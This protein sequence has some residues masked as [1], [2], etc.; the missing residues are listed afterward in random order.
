M[1][2]KKVPWTSNG[3]NPSDRGRQADWSSHGNTVHG[4][5]DP[6]KHH[7]S[8]RQLSKTGRL[9]FG[10]ELDPSS[11]QLFS[12]LLVMPS[13][14]D[15]CQTPVHPPTAC[16]IESTYTN[17]NATQKEDGFKWKP[18]PDNTRQEA[19]KHTEQWPQERANRSPI[20]GFSFPASHSTADELAEAQQVLVHCSNVATGRRRGLSLG[21]PVPVL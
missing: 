15:I 18:F 8:A 14:D 12:Q 10:A 4:Q 16:P 6:G 3:L 19:Q 5:H 11:L 17:F 1:G 13:G 21:R 7:E 20:N 9:G 2:A